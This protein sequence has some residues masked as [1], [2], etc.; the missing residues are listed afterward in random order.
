MILELLF[1]PIFGLFKFILGL[2]PEI[3]FPEQG[4]T[5]L[6]DFIDFIS[7]LNSFIP[8]DTLAIIVPIILAVHYID[9]LYTFFRFIIRHIPFLK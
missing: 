8:F 7:V 4:V 1:T 9:V 5:A 6:T 2:F 3:D